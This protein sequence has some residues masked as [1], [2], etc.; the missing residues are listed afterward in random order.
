VWEKCRRM[1][2]IHS[3]EAK[4]TE[5]SAIHRG[6]IVFG[7]LSGDWQGEDVRELF[8]PA[9][10]T[11]MGGDAKRGSVPSGEAARN[12]AWS[13]RRA[14]APKL[15]NTTID[16]GSKNDAPDRKQSDEREPG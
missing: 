5:L 16:P 1:T 12:R 11:R 9:I 6:S 15:G 7:P 14:E 4:P 3:G 10:V 2:S 8:A 13:A